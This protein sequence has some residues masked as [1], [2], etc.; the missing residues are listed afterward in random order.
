MDE[1]NNGV[2]HFKNVVMYETFFV[3]IYSH[4]L[5]HIF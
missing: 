2:V 3:H 4:D 1:I 5:Y